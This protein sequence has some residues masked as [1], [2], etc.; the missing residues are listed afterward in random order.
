MEKI[1]L[2]RLNEYRNLAGTVSFAINSGLAGA[3]LLAEQAGA[4]DF[5]SWQSNCRFSIQEFPASSPYSAAAVVRFAA[6]VP[7]PN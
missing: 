4:M 3:L 1:F 5:I 2:G 6:A 7:S